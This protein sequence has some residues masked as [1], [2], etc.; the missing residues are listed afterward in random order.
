[1]WHDSLTQH[2]TAGHNRQP[3]HNFNTS[4]SFMWHDS[5]TQHWHMNTTH[6]CDMTHKHNTS[7]SFLCD[8][9]HEHNT[10][11][12]TQHIHVT[13]LINTTHH[14]YC[15]W[16]DSCPQHRLIHTT[17]PCDM[18][19]EHNTAHSFCV[20]WL[21]HTTHPCDMTHNHN[22]VHSYY[23][24]WLMHTTHPCDMTHEHN[25]QDTIANLNIPTSVPLVYLLEETADG[26][27]KPVKQENAYAPMSGRYVC[28]YEN[29]C[30]DMCIWEYV[31][32]RIC[33]YKNMSL[34]QNACVP[35]LTGMCVY[36]RR[37]VRICV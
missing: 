17:H 30:A 4:H 31:Y 29:M 19:P 36:M 12:W 11:T 21:I 14:I 10:G 3:Q 23:V 20:T 7:H 16:H 5:W 26:G 9:T 22:T 24:T 32:M 15:M 27:L 1:M 18:T 6:S 34:Y 37:C 8:M 33:V 25:T 28:A 2:Y 13:W 35:M